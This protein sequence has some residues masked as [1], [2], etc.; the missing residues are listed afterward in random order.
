MRF[1]YKRGY[2]PNQTPFMMN[3]DDMAKTAQLEQFDE[4]LVR[5]MSYA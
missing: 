2:N 3:K 4:E 1:L 5:R